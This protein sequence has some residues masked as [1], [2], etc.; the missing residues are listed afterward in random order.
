LKMV[1]HDA[2]DELKAKIITFREQFSTFDEV[3]TFLHEEIVTDNPD[4]RGQKR[5]VRVFLHYMYF[6]CDIGSHA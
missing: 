5:L 4:V 1:Y 3:L 6:D 2:A